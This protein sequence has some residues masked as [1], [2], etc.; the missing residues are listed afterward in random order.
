MFH[1]E[2]LPLQNILQWF[3]T[4]QFCHFAHQP[5]SYA[6]MNDFDVVLSDRRRRMSG[7]KVVDHSSPSMRKFIDPRTCYHIWN[8]ACQSFHHCRGVN[9]ARL[10]FVWASFWMCLVKK[11]TNFSHKCSVYEACVFSI[12]IETNPTYALHER[13]SSSFHVRCLR[14]ILGIRWHDKITDEESLARTGSGHLSATNVLAAG[15]T[16]QSCFIWGTAYRVLLQRCPKRR[17]EII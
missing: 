14:I 12:L 8:T 6:G 10:L 9:W 7:R 16:S 3:R 1:Q 5:R 11:I 17:S 15:N 2:R 13:R 4:T